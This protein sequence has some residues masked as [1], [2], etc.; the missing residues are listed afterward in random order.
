MKL[1]HETLDVYQCSTKFLS[2][3]KIIL[4]Q[5]PRGHAPL[6]DQLR[7]ASVPILLN[8]AEGSGKVGLVDKAKFYGIARGSSMECGAAL[9]A[10]RILELSDEV[11]TAEAKE[12]LVRIVSMLSK[13]CAAGNSRFRKRK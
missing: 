13:M 8:I 2:L 6:A 4:E 12:L 7:R 11:V 3:A 5:I 1:I 10:C 9:D